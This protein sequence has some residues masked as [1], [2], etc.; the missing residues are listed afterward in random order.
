MCKLVIFGL[1]IIVSVTNNRVIKF[2]VYYIDWWESLMPH[3]KL[4]DI[5]YVCSYPFH[6]RNIHFVSLLEAYLCLFEGTDSIQTGTKESQ[7]ILESRRLEKDF[8][9]KR[10]IYRYQY[11]QA[12]YSWNIHLCQREWRS[13]L[14]GQIRYFKWYHYVTNS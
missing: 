9:C 11:G 5:K 8:N 12:T 7:D 3:S 6:D 1:R 4:R 10:E 2:I 14:L 13:W